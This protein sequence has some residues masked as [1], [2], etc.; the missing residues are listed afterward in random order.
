MNDKVFSEIKV[1]RATST[2]ELA[3]EIAD[4]IYGDFSVQAIVQ[5]AGYGRR[6]TRWI[7]KEGGLYMTLSLKRKISINE[8]PTLSVKT[9]EIV[10]E[11]LA[12]K[13]I[14][15]KIKEPN[16][17]MV[18]AKGEDKKICGILIESIKQSEYYRLFIGIG[19]NVNNDPPKICPAI[20]V[21]QITGKK[22][23]IDQ[24]ARDISRLVREKI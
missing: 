23:D 7:S 11:Y 21:Y 1:E 22:M 16:D 4:K 17:L 19:L 24:M 6:G 3:K 12:K 15:S 18:K 9:A 14:Y 20:S 13:G 10:K 8:L 5:S 2:Q